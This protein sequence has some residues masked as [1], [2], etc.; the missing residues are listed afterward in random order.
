MATTAF[1]APPK[2]ATLEDVLERVGHVPASRILLHPT[3][4]TATEADLVDRKIVGVRVC[5]LV[6]GILVEKPMGYREDSIGAWMIY[7]LQ[8]FL[9][10]HNLGAVAGAQGPIKL[11]LDV[12]RLP[13][14]SFIRWDS[15]DDSDTIEDP[16][17][18]TLEAVPDLVI[19]VLSPSNTKAEMA[20]KL[21]EY[22]KAGV[23]L[24]WYVDPK[25]SEVTVYPNGLVKGRKVVGVDGTLDGGTILP[26][27]TLPVAT[28][29]AKRAPGKKGP[30]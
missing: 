12:I 19:E 10:T 7:L 17:G 28:I 2:F 29:F 11:K 23:A 13:D 8:H 24:V 20:I 6:E 22:A 3:P 30:R 18:P 4:G 5:E 26:G 25:R 21:D 14:V 16:D 27:F 9:V 15:V 1:G